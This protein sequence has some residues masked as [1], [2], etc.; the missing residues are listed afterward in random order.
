[1]AL[2]SAAILL[3][4]AVIFAGCR[5]SKPQRPNILIIT[6]VERPLLA[7]WTVVGAVKIPVGTVRD[8][9]KLL[10]NRPV[11]RVAIAHGQFAIDSLY[12]NRGYYSATVTVAV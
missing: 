7:S 2:R 10:V 11:D 12:H 1:M 4:F 6:V 5:S 3:S 8:Q 9:V